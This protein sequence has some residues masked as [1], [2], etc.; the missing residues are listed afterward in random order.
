MAV[1]KV[2][3]GFRPLIS[4]A[5][6]AV[7]TERQRFFGFIL[8]FILAYSLD[9]V[10]PWVV[11]YTLGVFI[12]QGV[13][14]ASALIAFWGLLG[15]A[16]LRLLSTTAHHLARYL[17]AQVAY[18]A[19]MRTM[20]K[21]FSTLLRFPLRWHIAQHSGDA[22][23]RLSRSTGAIDQTIGTFVWQIIE[24]LVKIVFAGIA[25]FTLDAYV[26]V[27]V[28]VLSGL[29]VFAMIYF[30]SIL[31]PRLRDNN[32]F[33]DG[34]NR[35]CIDNLQNI[36][37]IKTLGLERAA[38]DQ[39]KQQFPAG[40]QIAKRISSYM[41]L[42]WGATG[43]GAVLVLSTSLVIYFYRNKV[44]AQ[45]FD[46]AQVYVLLNYL[47]R[48][49]QAIGS[50]NGYYGALM[51]SATA[52]EDAA[53]L[54]NDAAQLPVAKAPHPLA[55][56][57][58]LELRDLSF[59][60]P[61]NH[62]HTAKRHS[63]GISGVT[64]SLNPAERIA[65]VGQSGGGKSTLLK[66]LAGVIAPDSYRL[67]A[68]QGSP[69]QSPKRRVATIEEFHSEVLLVPQEPEIFAQSLRYNLEMGEDFDPIALEEAIGI[70]RL[71]SVIKRLPQGLASDLAQSGLDLSGGERQRVALARGILRAFKR[72]VLLLDEPTSSLDAATEQ[73]IFAALLSRFREHT[74][75][76]SVHRL[77]LIPHFTRIL[78]MK[79]GALVEDGR[80]ETLR[81][82]KGGVFAKMWNDFERG[83]KQ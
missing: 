8:L 77:N 59:H 27:N 40:L 52:Y 81:K 50:F 41:E 80:F 30:Q 65:L 47:D 64:I 13:T 39:L 55:G 33:S 10:V 26:A 42:K 49:F 69:T 45:A 56:W 34:I 23:G 5:W 12:E 35:I 6:E 1:A 43:V 58:R 16:G 66:I 25:V 17:Q 83:S 29:T 82:H 51:E 9:L 31:T 28:L 72:S 68:I 67:E 7:A 78:V 63:S 60:Y 54:L 11:G 73:E 70:C 38:R 75:I 74:I 4:A 14:D 61:E 2:K 46:V 37:T 32:R 57:R 53:K 44:E 36:V 21:L 24:G 22:L 48:I 18:T 15:Y 79:D 20:E 3:V 62:E 71:D 76:A 19:R